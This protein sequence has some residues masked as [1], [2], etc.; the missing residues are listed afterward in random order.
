MIF[1]CYCLLSDRDTTYVGFTVDVERRLRQHNQEIQ[2]GAKYTKGL[3]W[4]RIITVTGFPTKVSALQFE[5][6]WKN[7]TR[8]MRGAT[9]VERRCSAL[10]DLLNSEQSTSNAEPFSSYESPLTVLL[11]EEEAAI[12][13]RDKEVRYGIFVE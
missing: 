12:H 2:G 3:H 13:L 7:I 5:W 6:K 8:K 4:K 9:A 11:E 10:V 1:C